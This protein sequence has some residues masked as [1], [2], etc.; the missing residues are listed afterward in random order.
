MEKSNF[1]NLQVF[2]LAENLSDRIWH[3]VIKWSY[4]E[5]DTLGKQIIRAADSI[6]ANIAEGSG[7]YNFADNRRFVKIARGSL[8]ETRYWL[9]RAQMRQ[10]LTIEQ[11]NVLKPIINELSPKLN[12]YLKYLDNASK[13]QQE[14]D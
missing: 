4:F 12:A 11:V 1:E 8:Y 5:K 2:Q 7:R 13:K 14:T 9:K 6:G 3:I 10:L